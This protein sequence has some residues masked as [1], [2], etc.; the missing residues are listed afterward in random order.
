MHDPDESRNENAFFHFH[1]KRK[2]NEL[3]QNLA[4]TKIFE[5]VRYFPNYL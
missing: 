2:S 1:K 3:S 4:Y 5:N